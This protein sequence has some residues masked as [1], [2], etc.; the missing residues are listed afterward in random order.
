[1]CTCSFFN[2]KYVQ[3]YLGKQIHEKLINTHEKLTYRYENK[4]YYSQMQKQKE[5]KSK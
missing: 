2:T 1:M 4:V 5:A 3:K